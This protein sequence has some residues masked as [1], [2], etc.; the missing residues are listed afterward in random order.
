L[1]DGVSVILPLVLLLAHNPFGA[2]FIRP[3]PGGLHI[4]RLSIPSN[5]AP[6]P[7]DAE[8]TS[9]IAKHATAVDVSDDDAAAAALRDT[10]CC[11]C[12]E[13][14]LGAAADDAKSDVVQLKCKCHLHMHSVCLRK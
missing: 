1:D 9:M 4:W 3:G 12:Q 5:D 11:I 8:A 2:T 13:A 6:K 7:T 10:K 14:L